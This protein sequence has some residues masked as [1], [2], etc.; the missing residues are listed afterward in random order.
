V[1]DAL[2]RNFERGSGETPETNCVALL[3]SL[4]LVYSSLEEHQ[5]QDPFCVDLRDKIQAGQGSDDNFQMSKGLLCYYPKGTRI[6]RWIV[7]VSLR[8]LLLKYFHYSVLSGHLGAPKTVQ[9][10]AGNIYWTKKRAEIFDY[11][12]R[13]EFCQRAKPAQ[14][15]RVGLHSS[16]P[17]S[18]HIARLFTDFMGPLTSSKRGNIAILVAVSF[19]L[20]RKISS[21]VVCDCLEKA[22]FPAYSTPVSIVTDNAKVF[23]CKQIRDLCFRWEIIHIITTTYHP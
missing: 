5:K 13:C 11:V 15:T 10:I 1:A 12:H 21:Q 18:E 3:Q 20:V 22:F 4:P 16:S 2:P 23:R 19:F 9:K 17:V 8:P 7:L 14:N 6:R